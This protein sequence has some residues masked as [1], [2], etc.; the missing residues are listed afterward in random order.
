[1]ANTIFD[2]SASGELLLHGTQAD[3]VVEFNAGDV[4]SEF[5]KVDAYFVFDGKNTVTVPLVFT[6]S[7]S[8]E[9]D[10][11]QISSAPKLFSKVGIYCGLYDDTTTDGDLYESVTTNTV[12]L[13]FAGKTL[14]DYG[15]E[16]AYTKTE[17]NNLLSGKA[18]KSEIPTKVSQLQNDAGY[19]TQHQDISGKADKSEIPTKVSQL[20]NDSGYLTQHQDISGKADKTYVDGLIGD[21]ESQLSQ[22]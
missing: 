11:K 18:D 13:T 4:L 22:V 14:A 2:L 5:N 20:Q 21:I 7:V 6:Q 8:Q 1:M 10:L 12:V 15:I 17:A 9:I 3:A 19:L 16:D